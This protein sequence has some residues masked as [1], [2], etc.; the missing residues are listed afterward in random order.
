M[1]QQGGDSNR[2]P[3]RFPAASHHAQFHVAYPG[4]HLI[5]SPSPVSDLPLDG[6][7]FTRC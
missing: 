1:L 6:Y 2:R 3:L 5:E 7:T 4:V